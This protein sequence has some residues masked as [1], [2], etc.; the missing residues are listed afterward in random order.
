VAEEDLH[1][2]GSAEELDPPSTVLVADFADHTLQSAADA[3][4]AAGH[5]MDRPI[6]TLNRPGLVEALALPHNEV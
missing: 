2:A 3:L 6:A 1:R 4:T 5:T